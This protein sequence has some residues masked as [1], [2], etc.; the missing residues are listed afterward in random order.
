MFDRVVIVSEGV[1]RR[2]DDKSGWEDDID[3]G[4]GVMSITGNTVS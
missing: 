4:D 1:P 3:E 2:V